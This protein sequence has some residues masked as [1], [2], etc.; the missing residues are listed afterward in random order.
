MADEGVAD[1]IVAAEIELRRLVNVVMTDEFG[2]GWAEKSGAV[3][4]DQLARWR[5]LEHD[6]NRPGVVKTGDLLHFSSLEDLRQIVSKRWT[7][8]QPCL[9][10][11]QTFDVYLRRLRTL[12]NTVMHGDHLVAFEEHLALG[13]AGDLRNRVTLFMSE[14]GPHDKHFAR[15]EYVRDSFG[16]EAHRS[17]P[18]PEPFLTGLTLR[19]GDQVT[20]NCHGWHPEGRQLQWYWMVPGRGN[21]EVD[22]STFTWDIHDIDVSTSQYV[23]VTLIAEGPYHRYGTHDGTLAFHYAVL[24]PD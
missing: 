2:P 24:P 17:G 3:R 15:I 5:K 7:L 23:F 19:P 6:E 13:I 1:G 16:N 22:G 4:P 11:L 18:N 8:F 9:T 12:R 14:R 10:D 21:T 20:F